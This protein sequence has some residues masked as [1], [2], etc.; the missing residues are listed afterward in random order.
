MAQNGALTKINQK[1][2]YP[3]RRIDKGLIWEAG[4]TLLLTMGTDGWPCAGLSAHLGSHISKLS[5]ITVATQPYKNWAEMGLRTSAVNWN[6]YVRSFILMH[7]K[8]V[9]FRYDFNS[10][11]SGSGNIWKRL[12]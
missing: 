4:K 3:E 6:N 2:F 10:S 7:Q 9:E 8:Y 1:F 12:A 5:F 11:S